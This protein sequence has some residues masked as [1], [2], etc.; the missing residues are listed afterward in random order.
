MGEQV[1]A[2]SKKKTSRK[3][4]H[5]ETDTGKGVLSETERCKVRSRWTGVNPVS[6]EVLL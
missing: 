1:G 2:G 6:R 3:L 5:I 4:V